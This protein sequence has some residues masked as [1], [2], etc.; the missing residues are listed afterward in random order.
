MTEESYPKIY[1]Y[2]RIVQSKLYIDENFAEDID[3]ECIADQAFFS[4]F[5]FIRLFRKIYGKTPHA[6]LS[7]VRI[8]HAK[9]L[10]ME[11]LTVT[12]VC[13]AVGFDSVG[14]FAGLF[15]RRVGETPSAYQLYQHQRKA[16]TIQVPLRFIPGVFADK[17]AS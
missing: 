8:E 11:N 3:L 10:L 6:Y 13:F 12:Q 16:E 1:L 15:K 7:L 14:S 2:R 4:K 9:Q 17:I 5:H